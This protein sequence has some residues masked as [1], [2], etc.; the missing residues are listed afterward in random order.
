ML[1]FARVRALAIVGVLG[2]GAAVF[3][4]MALARDTQAERPEPEACPPGFV[5]ADIRMPEEKEV[6][7]NVY[8]ATDS[9]GL[10]A[11]VADNLTNREFEVVDHG[12]DPEGQTVDGVA[13]LRYGPK[14]VG[15]AQLLRAYF[16][17]E[18]ELQFDIER[19]DDV[20]DV[21]LGAGFQQLA[22]PTEVRQAIA[23]I[24]NPILPEGTCAAQG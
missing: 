6:R 19:K 14:A 16:L 10:A 11:G 22:T 1:S 17:N 3:V 7:V 13:L 24:G 2:I 21:L 12:N 5:E 4:V 20:V 23:A 8:N 18:A 15:D 9:A